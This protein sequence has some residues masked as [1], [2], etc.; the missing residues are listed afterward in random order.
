MEFF[1]GVLEL[2]LDFRCT[3]RRREDKNEKGEQKDVKRRSQASF[4]HHLLMT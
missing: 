2:E 4:L 3:R 1:I